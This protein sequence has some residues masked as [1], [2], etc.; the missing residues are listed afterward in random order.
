MDHVQQACQE[1]QLVSHEL[2]VQVFPY[3]MVAQGPDTEVLNCAELLSIHP[4]LC[5][6]QLHWAGHVLGMD[7]QHL[8]KCP[9]FGKLIEGK[10]STG[11]QKK[12]FKDTLKASLRD[13]CIDPDMWENLTSDRAS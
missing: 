4:Y 7:A 5:K 10:R 11:G 9:L 2:L 8:P 12:H 3:P 13:F 6:A 1:T